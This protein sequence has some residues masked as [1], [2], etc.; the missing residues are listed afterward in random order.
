MCR[1]GFIVS[2]VWRAPSR[3]SQSAEWVHPPQV[4][5]FDRPPRDSPRPNFP[6]T[7]SVMT[8]P[9][10]ILLVDDQPSIR[11]GLRMRLALEP[12]FE[13]VGEAS[14]GREAL[15]DAA[16][17]EPDVVLMD[18]EMPEMDGIYATEELTRTMP[19]CAV[20]VLSIHDD[21][22]TQERALAAGAR[23]FVAKHQCELLT[24]AIRSAAGA[25]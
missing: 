4:I 23:S 7:A 11:R 19:A 9:I 20:V 15:L 12:D 3:L 10:R 18:I 25:G 8:K 1:P 16:R 17:W 2:A 22:L 6:D 5:G 21:A 14:D 13:V 24:G